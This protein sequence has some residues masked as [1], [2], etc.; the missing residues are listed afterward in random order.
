MSL[1]SIQ[2]AAA[3]CSLRIGVGVTKNCSSSVEPARAVVDD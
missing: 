1:S 2:S 3:A